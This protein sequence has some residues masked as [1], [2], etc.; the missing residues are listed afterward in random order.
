MNAQEPVHV[1]PAL[2]APRRPRW[3]LPVIVAAALVL[4]VT[5]AALAAYLTGVF[6]DDGRFAAEPAACATVTPSLHLLG[7][8]YTA[9]EDENNNC[10]L[11]LPREHPS[12][13][14]TP[15]IIVGYAAVVPETGDAEDAARDELRRIGPGQQLSGVGDEAYAWGEKNV[16]FRV[17]N[18][19][20]GVTV[21]PLAP[22]TKEQL[23][24]FAADMADRL[25]DA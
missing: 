7:T 6:D 2:A 1:G 10:D 4:V 16:V 23:K 13:S 3:R 19:V 22:S 18:L 11:L 24:T 25:H 5:I 8:A 20:V 9:Q 12:Y 14:A 21:F 15:V 17:S